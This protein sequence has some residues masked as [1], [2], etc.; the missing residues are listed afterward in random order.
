MEI[1]DVAKVILLAETN[2]DV[3]SD[4][5]HPREESHSSIFP[6]IN[7]DRKSNACKIVVFPAPFKPIRTVNF[8]KSMRKST[9]DLKFET[10]QNLIIYSYQWV[11]RQSVT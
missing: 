10:S 6:F 8:G 7:C 5:S 9:K 3:K 2:F 11:M 1:L 4:L